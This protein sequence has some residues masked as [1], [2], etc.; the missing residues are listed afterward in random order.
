VIV[1]SLALATAAAFTWHDAEGKLELRENGRPVLVYNYGPQLKNGAPELKRRSG[2][3]HPLWAPN[4]VV[5]TDDFPRDHWHHRGVFWAWPVVRRDGKQYDIWTLTGG[6]E[7]RFSKWLQKKQGTT[8]E[9][10]VENQWV[11]AGTPVLRETI[12]LVVNPASGNQQRIGFTLTFEAL[13]GPI[14]LAGSPDDE[15]GY[16]GFSVRFAPRTDTVIRPDKGVEAR[17]TDMVPHPWA[18]LLANYGGKAARLRIDQDQSNPG[19][20]AGWCLRNYGFLGVNYPGLRPLRLD[21]G[22][23]VK[24]RY[25]VTVA[26]E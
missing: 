2:Y 22:K 15:K 8:A 23:P 26:G 10:A 11:I 1:L 20:P 16:G 9:L 25:E 14:E 3:I 7:S 17:D 12:A 21:P 19:H 5:V 24:L 4:G 18:E 13:G 6:I